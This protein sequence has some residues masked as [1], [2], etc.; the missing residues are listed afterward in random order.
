MNCVSARELDVAILDAFTAILSIALLV[1]R[2]GHAL[3]RQQSRNSTS[4]V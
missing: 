2:R 1:D 3:R 4:T